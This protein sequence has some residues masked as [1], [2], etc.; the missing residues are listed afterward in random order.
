MSAVFSNFVP[1]IKV[2]IMAY[3]K[4]EDRRQRTL[5]PDCIDDYVEQDS[6]VRLMDA[7][8]DCLDMEKLG[9]QRFVPADT[10]APGYDP[11][12][13]LK[14]YTYGYYYEVRSSRKLARQCLINIEVMWLLSKLTPDFRT[15]SDFRKDNKE[16]IEKTFKEFNRFCLGENLFS[17]NFVS[18]DGSKFK[19]VNAKDRNFTLNKLDDRIA[20]LD[21]HIA[22]YMDELDAYDA[23]EGRKLSKE[24]LEHKLK[25]CKERKELYE[26]YREQLEQS[27]AKQMSLT[28]PDSRLMK[29]NEGFCVGYN[30][31]MAVDAE[32]HMIA[33]FQMTNNPTDHGQITN[34]AGDVKQEYG[35]D[36]LEATA[37]KGY[38]CPEDYANALASGI[39]PNVIQ[40]N[41]GCTEE[42]K[43]DY[44]DVE[45][46]DEQ[47][48]STKPEDLKTCL[49]A[50]VVPDAYKDILTD[51]KVVEEKT[52]VADIADSDVLKMTD[53]EMKVKAAEGYFV[54]AAERN[55]VYCPQGQMLRQKSI[56]RNGM[57][58]YCNK[59]ACKHCKNRCTTADFKEVDFNKDKLIILA[60]GY[61]P[62]ASDDNDDERPKP[63]RQKRATLV[64]KV[65]KYVLHLDEKKMDQRKCLSEHPFGTLKR[66]LGQYY[67]LLKGFAKVTAEMALFC[68]SYNL[69]RA[70]NMKGVPA[71]V[72]ALR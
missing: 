44:H 52:Y 4:G 51:V 55:F 56:K 70:I 54:R 18:I 8:V 30:T 64:K 59:L 9:F 34:V 41:G 2:P 68:L 1:I 60:R 21:Q 37:D 43:F 23:E 27:G 6:P 10:G 39:V 69:R 31:Q 46:T 5:F 47:K 29:A 19:A 49:E 35:V 58:R 33:G 40:R 3:K 15:I 20:R 26:G 14:L 48:A 17:K 7:F 11:R 22:H 38:E 61:R 62:Q 66:S 28:D 53:A 36:I 45:I 32:S 42:V 65:V 72:T 57:I 71:L 50:G 67:F 13:L 25:N 16:A 63:P 24:D 12:D